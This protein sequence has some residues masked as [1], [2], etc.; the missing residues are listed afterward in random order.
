METIKDLWSKGVQLVK[1]NPVITAGVVI[2]LVV[3]VILF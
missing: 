2:A 3:L 1:D